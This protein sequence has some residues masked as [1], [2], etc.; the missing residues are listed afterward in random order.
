MRGRR[1]YRSLSRVEEA[2]F[3]ALQM[4]ALGFTIRLDSTL[5]WVPLKAT[6]ECR[7]RSDSA[8]P[9]RGSFVGTSQNFLAQV[10]R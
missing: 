5:G 7:I 6:V 2:S 10:L 8:R 1:S 9:N 3:P 4:G